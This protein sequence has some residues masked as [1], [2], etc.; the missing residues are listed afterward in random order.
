MLIVLVTVLQHHGEEVIIVTRGV[1]DDIIGAIAWVHESRR[2][3]VAEGLVLHTAEIDLP[4]VVGDIIF[5]ALCPDSRLLNHC[6]CNVV[7]LFI[8]VLVFALGLL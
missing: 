6:H 3:H 2:L 8:L 1:E 7:L 4:F 5:V